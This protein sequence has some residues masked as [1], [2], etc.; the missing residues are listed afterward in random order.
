MSERGDF[1][2]ESSDFLVFL[3][4]EFGGGG[5][6]GGLELGYF[7][8]VALVESDYLV[9]EGEDLI[10]FVLRVIGFCGVE[11]AVGVD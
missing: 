8:D 11:C 4:E 10:V 3:G 9:L 5:C 1:G 6:E 2:G 7:V